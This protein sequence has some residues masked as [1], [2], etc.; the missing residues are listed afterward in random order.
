M[1]VKLTTVI[2][3]QRKSLL[4]KNYHTYY[5]NKKYV[6]KNSNTVQKYFNEFLMLNR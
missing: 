5:L 2:N 1:C 4:V 6:L 3:L